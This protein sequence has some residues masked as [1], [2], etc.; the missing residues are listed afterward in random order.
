VRLRLLALAPVLLVTASLVPQAEAA[1]TASRPAPLT[2]PDVS[3]YQHANGKAINW[4]AVKRSGQD[5]AFIK[6]TGG[7]NRVDPW[8]E[9]EW[10]AAGKAGMIR[11][12]YHYADPAHSAVEQADRIVSVVGSTREANDL[13]IVL[14]LESTGGLGP[15]SLARWA[16]TFLSR[17]ERRTGRVPILYT[18]PH[19]WHTR[20]HDN[21]SFGAYPL[22]IAHYTSTRPAPLPGWNRWTFWQH[23][24]TAR[25]SGISGYVDHNIMCCSVA[26]LRA[27]ADGRSTRITRLWSSLGGASGQLGLPLGM[28]SVIPG[29][30]AQVFEHGYVV[31]SQRGTFAVTGDTWERYRANGGV[32]GPLGVPVAPVQLLAAGVTS[33]RFVGGRIVWSQATGAHALQ[34]DLEAR[35]LSDGA[36]AGV[37]GLPTGEA[38]AFAQ[39]FVGGGLY[40]TPTGVHFLPAAM[41][42]RY[43]ELGGPTGAMGLPVGETHEMLGG[44]AMDFDSGGTL[45]QIEIAGQKIVL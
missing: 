8:F 35:W 29:G 32:A 23:T 13:G 28:E 4:V 6:A 11:G 45:Y 27:L 24:N 30:W 14:D 25:V 22:W 12:A 43:E 16:H 31:A 40:R 34:G 17:V 42:D 36:A 37:E 5:F 19:F 15:A 7:S 2:G 38:T 26:T 39:D 10:A 18:G 33:Q 21:R 41:R 3:K 20:M 44:V 9:R 1:S